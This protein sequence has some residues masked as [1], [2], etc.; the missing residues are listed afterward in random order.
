MTEFFYPSQKNQYQPKLKS[1]ANE[2]KK[3][4]DDAAVE[5]IIKDDLPFNHFRKEAGMAKFLS[6][7]KPGYQGPNRKYV[8]KQLARLYKQRRK[9]IKEKLSSVLYISLTTDVWKSPTRQYF[10]CLT[11]HF[12]NSQYENESF[13]LSFRRFPD[14][15]SGKKFRSFIHNELRKMNLEFKVCSITTDSGPDIKCATT[16]VA[17]FGIRISCCAHNFNLIVQNAL[18]LFKTKL[19]KKLVNISSQYFY[20]FF[21]AGLNHHLLQLH[22]KKILMIIV[23]MKHP[24]HMI[25][26]IYLNKMPVKMIMILMVLKKMILQILRT[27]HI[28]HLMK[29]Y[30]IVLMK[31]KMKMK[32][33][34]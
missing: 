12:V 19:P 8:R 24:V 16:N 5:A 20:L 29:N 11:C 34:L 15:H 1:I 25:M 3:K 21:F 17:A 33:E 31:M 27:L 9:L 4:F 23:M 7:I 10:I 28:Y 22:Q 14:K 26:K 6:V 2:E 30:L 13:V 18:W 32:M